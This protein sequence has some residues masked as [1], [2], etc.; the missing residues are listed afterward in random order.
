MM[1]PPSAMGS[2]SPPKL[3]AFALSVPVSVSPVRSFRALSGSIGS[4]SFSSSRLVAYTGS[5]HC[6]RPR[7][8]AVPSLRAIF[9]TT[10]TVS[11][12]GRA[13]LPD[14]APFIPRTLPNDQEPCVSARIIL[15]LLFRAPVLSRIWHAEGLLRFW[16]FPLLTIS[17]SV[18]E[19]VFFHAKTSGSVW[20]V[21]VAG[22]RPACSNNGPPPA[23]NKDIIIGSSPTLPR[24]IRCRRP[25]SRGCSPTWTVTPTAHH[26]TKTSRPLNRTT[27]TR[28]GRPRE[29]REVF[30]RR[31]VAIQ[32]WGSGDTSLRPRHPRPIR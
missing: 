16:P 2:T 19:G 13:S 21:R 22:D 17:I 26:A 7:S 10:L 11:R 29:L 30:P 23:D 3:T 24:Y 4:E 12:R 18:S 27:S 28:S 20:A 25:H 8:V 9:I 15:F 31:R 32:G 14:V 5:D 1:S 6:R